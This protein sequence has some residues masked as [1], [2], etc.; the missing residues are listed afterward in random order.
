MVISTG[1]ISILIESRLHTVAIIAR[2]AESFLYVME[3]VA[4][5]SW[6][7]KMAVKVV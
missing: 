6:N 4:N 2:N 3:D 1:T 5:V 7:Q